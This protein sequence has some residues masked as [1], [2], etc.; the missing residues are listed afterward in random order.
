V[1]KV[2]K[3]PAENSNPGDEKQ[4]PGALKPDDYGT[5]SGIA[6]RLLL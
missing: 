6:V 3:G 1:T 5:L 4:D 2:S